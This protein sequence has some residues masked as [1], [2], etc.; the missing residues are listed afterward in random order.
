MKKTA[1]IIGNSNYPG[2]AFL[3]NPI[4]DA[5]DMSNS[6]KKV[7][8]SVILELN[9]DNETIDRALQRFE[10]NL[11]KNEIGL[12]YFAGHGVQVNGI[13]YLVAVDSKTKDETALKHSSTSLN[14]ILDIMDK[15][16][17]ETNIIILDACRD[18]PFERAWSRDNTVR[19]FANVFAP[20]GTIISFSTSPGQYASDGATNNSPFAYALLTHIQTPFIAIEELFKR[21][22]ETVMASTKDEQISWE[23]T[24]LVG[25]F[26]F[27]SGNFISVETGYDDQVVADRNFVSSGSEIEK[28]IEELGSHDWYS[29]N[30]AVE[31]TYY[32]KPENE[33]KNLLFLLGRNLLQAA[34]GG[35]R[36]AISYI[37]NLEEIKRFNI[38]EENHLLNGLLFEIY[39]DSDGKFRID[40][41]KALYIEEVL[42]LF[43]KKDF[44]ASLIFI[45]QQLLPFKDDL[46]ILP[47][48]PI[49][50]I[51]INLVFEKED[52]KSSVLTEIQFEGRNI[53]RIDKKNDWFGHVYEN[54]ENFCKDLSGALCV[55]I[56]QVTFTNNLGLTGRNKIS[57]PYRYELSKTIQL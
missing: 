5:V 24:S 11:N 29:Q 48:V 51:S 13:N 37:Q 25:N 50:T 10:G 1:L 19:G 8:F 4:N 49:E 53:L 14:Q 32:L 3:K 45:R 23:H 6:L 9:A 43:Q 47:N 57:K 16:S 12:F 36:K 20:K 52:E 44:E 39:F 46:Y 18:N 27:N 7:G 42:N 2:K 22:R 54:Y 38:S 35:A 30:P 40:G 28:I 55:P 31:K 26:Q 34:T 41:F 15:S 21:V 56:K 17:N 33:D